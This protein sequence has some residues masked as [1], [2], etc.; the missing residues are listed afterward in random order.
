MSTLFGK[1]IF[2]ELSKNQVVNTAKSVRLFNMLIKLV[3]N[4]FKMN[5]KQ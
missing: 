1:D 4:G 5:Y 2:F 3:Y